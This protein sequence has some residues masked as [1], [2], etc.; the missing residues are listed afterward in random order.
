KM[1]ENYNGLIR[2]E[3]DDFEIFQKYEG[4]NKTGLTGYD[5]LVICTEY[6]NDVHLRLWVDHGGDAM[7]V[8]ALF[9]SENSV[10]F[11]IVYKKELKTR[12]S[13][14]KHLEHDDVFYLFQF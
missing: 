6:A 11:P 7:P 9:K 8:G 14:E 4:K 5:C 10:V 2:V 12:N 13:Y 3:L 1:D